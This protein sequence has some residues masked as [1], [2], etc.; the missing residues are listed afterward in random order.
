MN[1]R[2]ISGGSKE[3]TPIAFLTQEPNKKF[4]GILRDGSAKAIK[5]A[6]GEKYLFKFA[7]EDGDVYLAIKNDK[8]EYVEA[9]VNPGDLVTV[10]ATAPLRDKLLQ[11]KIGERVEI[12]YNGKKISPKSGNNYHDFSVSVLEG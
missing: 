9:A 1:R 4:V 3:K 11:C 5:L 2:T 6:R 12:V 10:L 8:D 7:V